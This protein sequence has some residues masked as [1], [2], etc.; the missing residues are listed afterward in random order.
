MPEMGTSGGGAKEL[1]QFVLHK[2]ALLITAL[3]GG[4]LLLFLLIRNSPKSANPS[5]VTP[6]GN[7][8]S[9]TMDYSAYQQGYDTGYQR[10]SYSLSPPVSS[11]P[12]TTST[13]PLPDHPTVTTQIQ[14]P[15]PTATLGIVR[16]LR[17]GDSYDASHTG[18]PIASTLQIGQ[19]I[20]TVPYG[21][22][23]AIQGEPVVGPTSPQGTN[24]Y[25]KIKYGETTGY[26]S[27]FDIPTTY[28]TTG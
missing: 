1:F 11:V 28:Q 20:G 6:I 23:V 3:A 12:P 22:K 2:P 7:T 14:Q 4:A 9:G 13:S 26:A 17:A 15:L 10:A 27:S 5:T 16:A 19:N 24:T 8:T 18:I 25:Y 21:E